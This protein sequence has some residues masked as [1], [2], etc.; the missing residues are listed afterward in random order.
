MRRLGAVAVAVLV[1]GLVGGCYH[2]EYSNQDGGRPIP[3]R[4]QPPDP[5]STVTA[6]ATAGPTP[7][8]GAYLTAQ[9]LCT[10]AGLYIGTVQSEINSA[11]TEAEATRQF[12][13]SFRSYAQKLRDLEP[14]VQA[15]AQR[16]AIDRAATAADQL[17][18]DVEAAGS[19]KTVDD[20]PALQATQAAFPGCELVR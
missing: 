15:E 1:V 16:S 6:A 2:Y 18:R 12:V 17:A 4:A 19:F 7:S 20:Q 9:D 8:S 10:A 3:P 13:A 11:Q 14:R 5:T